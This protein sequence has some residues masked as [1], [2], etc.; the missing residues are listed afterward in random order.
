VPSVVNAGRAL[1]SRASI[2]Q[3]LTALGI[4]TT[5]ASL[6]IASIVLIIY[7]RSS[8]R[9]RL[10]RDTVS[11]ADVVGSNSTAALA[12]ADIRAAD[13][14]LRLVAVNGHI[15]S[16]ALLTLDG[17]VFAHY[18]R[19]G[20]RAPALTDITTARTPRTVACVR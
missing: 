9:E 14:T 19:R 15:T 7:D 1:I 3:K 11:L 20:Q 5:A 6:A 16:A 10:L 18:D 12:F 4:V 8:S 17:K 13:E 2:A